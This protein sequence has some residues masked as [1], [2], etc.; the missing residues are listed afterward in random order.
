M[1][2]T[3]IMIISFRLQLFESG[4]RCCSRVVLELSLSLLFMLLLLLLCFTCCSASAASS[5]S[6]SSPL[7]LSF[8]GGSLLRIVVTF[9][10]AACAFNPV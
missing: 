9:L 4:K 10:R 3:L 7:L 8:E 1:I 5:F 2:I 6:S